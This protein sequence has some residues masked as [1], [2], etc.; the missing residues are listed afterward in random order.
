M[1]ALTSRLAPALVF[2]AAVVAH[3]PSVRNGFVYDDQEVILAQPPVR[4][5]ADVARIFAEPHGL[6]QSRL[7]YYRP[8]A[9]ASLLIQKT[10]H[11]DQPAY[12]HAG[13]AL[14]AGAAALAGYALL[15]TPRFALPAA[16][17]GL[18]AVAFAVHPVASSV[19][20][21]IASGRESLLPAVF[22]L[23]TVAAHLRA[24]RRARIAALAGFALALWSKEQAIA[25]PAV[26]V[27]ADAL[28]LGADPPRGVRGFALRHAPFAAVLAVYLA[29]RAAI[30]GAAEGGEEVDVL[31]AVTAQLGRDPLGPLHSLAYA[32]QVAFAPF[33][34]VVYEPDLDAWWS[35]VR[36]G[37]ACAGLA[38][39]LAV[40]L[41][42]RADRAPTLFWLAW[43]PAFLALTMN[44]W[45]QE[46][47]Y[48]ERFVFLSSFG[49]V[50]LVTTAASRLGAGA[51][52][53][54]AAGLAI[55]AV[56]VL[57]A[58][59]VQRGSPYHDAVA[60]ARQWTRTSPRHANAHA[61]LGAA[62]ARDGEA[63]PAM[64]ALREAVR[65]EP[66]LAAAHY[67]LGVLLA[68]QGRRHEAIEHFRAALESDPGDASARSA[69]AQLTGPQP[70]SGV[71]P[72]RA[73]E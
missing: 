41:R 10:M 33:P 35:P 29:V 53:P 70:G 69:L 63:E 5:P 62:L 59:S 4:G 34:S 49:L 54:L 43:V 1:H 37:L 42:E 44:L 21:P 60:F 28:R 38:A 36:L 31:A 15:R 58:L 48:D 32:V 25:L 67:N 7:P 20:H 56:A 52:A 23:A 16:A 11:G 24:G 55:V 19:V 27:L 66:R 46:A 17:A 30:F 13:N 12:F 61:T 9:R 64:A 3:A 18:G 26:L 68:W 51:R 45:P 72:G 57:A 40:A 22:A 2:V 8:T 71:T 50:A 6:P 65:L 14:A 73:H 39:A 47:R